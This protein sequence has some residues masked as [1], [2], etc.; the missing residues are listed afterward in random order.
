MGAALI[1]VTLAALLAPYLFGGSFGAGGAT[2]DSAAAAPV[3]A[4]SG[5]STNRLRIVLGVGHGLATATLQDTPAA[6]Q[7]A[8]MLPLELS[9]HD[10]MGQA[11]SGLLPRPL[12]V[13]GANLIT[14]PEAATI[15]YWPPSGDIAI[16]YDDLGQTV[17]PPGLVRL[18]TIDRGLDVIATAGNQFTLSINRS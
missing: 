12:D 18:G 17:P 9:L 16:L 6:R 8:A 11:K 13:S 2:A 3:A 7:F 5:L 14:D 4:A 10:P 1:P 15:Y